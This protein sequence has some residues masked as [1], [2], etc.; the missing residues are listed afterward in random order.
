MLNI[1]Q[2]FMYFIHD[3]HEICRY[4][5]NTFKSARFSMKLTVHFFSCHLWVDKNIL[6]YTKFYVKSLIFLRYTSCNNELKTMV[7]IILSIITIFYKHFFKA[8][9][10]KIGR[11][12][13][14]KLKDC[15]HYFAIDILL[16]LLQ[17]STIQHTG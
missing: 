1:I 12:L 16:P 2:S 7:E 14:L 17:T 10:K 11:N 3:Q 6:A 15:R 8:Y 5:I 4:F 9:Y 13:V